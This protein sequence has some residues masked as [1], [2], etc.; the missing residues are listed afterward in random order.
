MTSNA[1]RSSGFTAEAPVQTR[2]T[3]G[4]RSLL[5]AAAVVASLSYLLSSL[6][7]DVAHRSVFRN[8]PLVPSKSNFA[9]LFRSLSQ[10]LESAPTVLINGSIPAW[11][12]GTWIKTGFCL[13]ES[14]AYKV[15]M[16]FDAAGCGYS[17]TIK[18]GQATI[19]AKKL[20]SNYLRA[21]EQG[22]YPRWRTFDE[23]QPSRSGIDL[24]A[25]LLS[26]DQADNFLVNLVS[27]GNNRAA[28]LTDLAGEMELDLVSMT[29]RGLVR[30]NDSME[31]D[32][33]NMISSAH[34]SRVRDHPGQLFNFLLN[35]NIPRNMAK[36]GSPFVYNVY[37]TD[38]LQGKRKLI[39]SIPTRH[40]HYVHENALTPNYFIII[41]FPF[42]WNFLKI[43]GNTAIKN[44]LEFVPSEGIRFKVI[45]LATGKLIGDVHLA[46]E[47]F[48][49]FHQVNAYEEAGQL[50]LFMTAYDD[51]G[52][53]LKN[54]FNLDEGHLNNTFDLPPATLRK[55]VIDMAKK[56]AASFTVGDVDFELPIVPD[57]VRGVK[58]RYCYA[59]AKSVSSR[60]ENCK[61]GP[62]CG[63]TWWDTI[64]KV[65]LESGR[66]VARWRQDDFW[67]SEPAYIPMQANAEDDGVLLNVVLGDGPRS[68][69]LVLDAKNL[70]ELARVALPVALPYQSHG[71]WITGDVQ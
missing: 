33:W 39:A 4:A 6:A 18:D 27:L 14:G 53:H 20:R 70:A 32:T 37:R 41:E 28:A 60:H 11:I 62:G 57:V 15:R 2:R 69:L 30:W 12:S 21:F 23:F 66:E 68:Y 31:A 51:I 16:L 54:S 3:G 47:S 52:Y 9:S 25:T 46:N 65:D 59:H 71:N 19:S 50:V 63:G 1:Q 17:I 55:V 34:P 35:M 13:F 64:I 26:Q 49:A 5:V 7:L 38:V 36:H 48:Y 10:E 58:N 45:E 43:I 44:A 24:L 61:A 67:P 40:H 29:T 42:F 8:A 22:K 56:T